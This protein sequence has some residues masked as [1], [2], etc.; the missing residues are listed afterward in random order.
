MLACLSFL[1]FVM[2]LLSCLVLSCC[3][4]FPSIS[5]WS[6]N[7]A[8]KSCHIY[9]KDKNGCFILDFFGSDP[10]KMDQTWSNLIKLDFS[11]IKKVLLLK[12]STFTERIKMA[13][14]FFNFFGSDLP[15]WIKL[16]Q[17]WSNMIKLDQIGFLTNQ[18]MLL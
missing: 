13:V 14:L 18:K 17:T 2:L 7:D 10:S 3:L 15:K 1:A 12:V 16:D 11:P 9:K 5:V 6:Q 4:P 8:I